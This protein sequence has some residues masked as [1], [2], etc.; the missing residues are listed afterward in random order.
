MLGH[1]GKLRKGKIFVPPFSVSE[2]PED[3]R[4]V[5][6]MPLFKKVKPRNY[7]PVSMI[8]VMG[9]LLEEI[10]KGKD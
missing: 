3:W 7:R 2:V 1:C 10:W 8:S 9:N 5:I 6:V 4:M